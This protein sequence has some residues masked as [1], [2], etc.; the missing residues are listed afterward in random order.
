VGIEVNDG[1]RKTPADLLAYLGLTVG[2]PVTAADRQAWLGKLRLSGRFIKQACRFEPGGDGCV[3]RFQ[4]VE[5]KRAAPLD[6]EASP[7]QQALLRARAW[8]LGEWH[9]GREIRVRATNQRANKANGPWRESLELITGREIGSV[10]KLASS[11]W[12]CA[13]ACV[14]GMAGLFTD[15]ARFEGSFVADWAPGATLKL[16]VDPRDQKQRLEV[17]WGMRSGGSARCAFQIEPVT[18]NAEGWTS[19]RVGDDLVIETTDADGHQELWL[20]PASGRPRKLVYVAES[21]RAEILCD[22]GA[23]LVAA[24]VADLRERAGKN[25]AD[26]HRPVSSAVRFA[27]ANRGLLTDAVPLVTA[28]TTGTT[29]DDDAV[30]QY[31]E[32]LQASV[33]G[34]GLAA[35]DATVAK[36]IRQLRDAVA[37]DTPEGLA[38]PVSTAEEMAGLRAM[39]ASRSAGMTAA[40]DGVPVARDADAIPLPAPIAGRSREP[41]MGRALGRKCA[42]AVAPVLRMLELKM[43]RDA[44]AVAAARAAVLMACTADHAAAARELARVPAASLWTPDLESLCAALGP[45]GR[46]LDRRA[47]EALAYLHGVAGDIAW[48]VA[49]YRRLLAETEEQHAWTHPETA[50]YLHNLVWL[51][52]QSGEAKEAYALAR[53]PRATIAWE[54]GLHPP[55]P[56]RLKQPAAVAK[57][58]DAKAKQPGADKPGAKQ[59]ESSPAADFERWNGLELGI[60]PGARR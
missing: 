46:A 48:S 9:A 8:L 3:A 41:W 1:L 15:T 4:L 13:L 45:Q 27:L 40:I 36:G 10:V 12:S 37:T 28:K 38:I 11:D 30:A 52:N 24:A 53:R 29:M 18:C 6:R 60:M 2:Q 33:D 19:R 17:G 5:Y 20:D 50:K 16:F 34:D 59:H 54:T 43:G 56:A 58:D 23:G 57:K 25:L 22:S 31:I 47:R 32:S 55:V 44:A 39:M 26:S 42:A 35:V 51:L 49:T 7:E 21:N 14:Q